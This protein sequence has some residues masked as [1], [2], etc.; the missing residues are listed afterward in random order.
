M[1]VL[2]FIVVFMLA[3]S[4]RPAHDSGAS[5]NAL[6]QKNET[7]QGKIDAISLEKS[8]V[9]IAAA[10]QRV[11]VTVTPDTQIRVNEKVGKL[12]DLQAG[13]TAT[14]VFATKEG[15]HT[16]ISIRVEALFN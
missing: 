7:L 9:T 11:T 16:A 15:R 10:D 5:Q 13:V 8:E 4:L 2:F 6:G 14:V 1:K 3:L 12:A